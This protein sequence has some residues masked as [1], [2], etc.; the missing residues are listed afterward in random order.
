MQREAR[1]RDIAQALQAYDQQEHPSGETLPESQRVYRV[2]VVTSFLEAGVPLNKL[3]HFREILEQH[4]G[5]W[6][7]TKQATPLSRNP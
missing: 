2:K 3:H 5:G 7:T 4:F 1:E 6:C